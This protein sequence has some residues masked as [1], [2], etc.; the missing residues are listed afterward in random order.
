MEVEQRYLEE[1]LQL[2]TNV[3]SEGYSQILDSLFKRQTSDLVEFTFDT[4][5]AAE[6]NIVRKSQKSKGKVTPFAALI[7]EIKELRL[8][9]TTSTLSMNNASLIAASLALQR[10][11]NAGNV[12]K[13]VKGVMKRSTQRVAGILAM[14]AATTAALEGNFDGMLGA[15]P[16][17]V[18]SIMEKLSTVFQN[19]GAVRLK[20]PL[21]R[22]RPSSKNPKTSVSGPAE[23]LN[24]RGSVLLLPEDLTA[25]L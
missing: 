14:S 1:A 2:L 22:P 4:D 23:V 25:P 8:S 9:T 11:R 7:Q 10:A 19:H 13:G 3:Q 24:S 5:V 20:N 21:L 17:L 6:A 18:D 12:G 15:D 16:R